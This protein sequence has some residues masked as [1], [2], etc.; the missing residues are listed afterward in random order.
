MN[1]NHIE[2]LNEKIAW[3]KPEIYSLDFKNTSSG[4]IT[5]PNIEDG[6][7]SATQS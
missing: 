7:Y 6:D 2:D 1:Q 3:E 4:Q 5:H